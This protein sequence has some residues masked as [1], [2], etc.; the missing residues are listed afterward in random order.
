[1]A[2]LQP[3]GDGQPQAPCVMVE[4]YLFVS[5]LITD[6]SAKSNQ[7][8]KNTK[9]LTIF[10]ENLYAQ[11]RRVRGQIPLRALMFEPNQKAAKSTV[12]VIPY[13]SA[14][15]RTNN[16]ICEKQ[17]T[18][19]SDFALLFR[20][21]VVTAE[22]ESDRYVVFGIA[23][24]FGASRSQMQSRFISSPIVDRLM[25]MKRMQL[26]IRWVQR[27]ETILLLLFLERVYMVIII[28]RNKT[29]EIG[30]ADGMEHQFPDGYERSIEKL[31]EEK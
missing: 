13:I 3:H 23:K 26:M 2:Q 16:A 6:L 4:S 9:A 1:M 17:Y 10:T 8:Q 19:L 20:G 15:E 12:V 30:P 22:T 28:K 29:F 7:L 25:R 5:N 24:Y 14:A 27:A 18:D 21:E 11:W 31:S